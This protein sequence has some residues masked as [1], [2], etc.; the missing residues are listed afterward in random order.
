M[1]RR[2]TIAS[3]RRLGATKL[4]VRS[5]MRLRAVSKWSRCRLRL[6][7]RVLCASTEGARS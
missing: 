7:E 1:N 5:G 2:C 3:S 6:H 4:T